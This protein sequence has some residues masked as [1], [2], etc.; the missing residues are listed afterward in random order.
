MDYSYV[1]LF[2]RWTF[3]TTDYSYYGLFVPS[4]K[5]LTMLTV[6]AKEFLQALTYI[7]C[8]CLSNAS[9]PRRKTSYLY[10]QLSYVGY[11]LVL[12]Q[13]LLVIISYCL[14]FVFYRLA[15]GLD[16]TLLTKFLMKSQIPV[17]LGRC[18][19][20]CPSLLTSTRVHLVRP[21]VVAS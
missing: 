13:L 7:G 4:V 20:L 3:L 9:R 18:Q 12:N 1:G 10:V 5:I 16:Y 15:V 21:V 2:V 14:V 17:D 6:S 11:F 8:D 19:L